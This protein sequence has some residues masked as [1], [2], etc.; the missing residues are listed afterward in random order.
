MNLKEFL[1]HSEQ[2]V[3]RFSIINKIGRTSLQRV[4]NGENFSIDMASALVDISGGEITY[5]ALVEYRKSIL[6]FKQN[7]AKAKS[8]NKSKK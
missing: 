1:K 4:L 8:T 7:Q 2:S 6:A 5:E 3:R